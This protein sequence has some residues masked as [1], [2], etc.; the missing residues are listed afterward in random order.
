M[1]RGMLTTY[2]NQL[3][4]MVAFGDDQSMQ[5]GTKTTID[6]LRVVLENLD[7]ENQANQAIY[8]D[9]VQEIKAKLE[10]RIKEVKERVKIQPFADLQAANMATDQKVKELEE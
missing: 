1:R 5:E 10:Q 4:Q 3:A 2:E 6:K 7:A 9:L 8:E